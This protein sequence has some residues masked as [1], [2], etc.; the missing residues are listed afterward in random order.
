MSEEFGA[1]LKQLRREAGFGLRQFAEMI[2]DAASNYADIESGVRQPWPRTPD[3]LRHVAESLGL[4][5]GSHKCDKLFMLASNN[6]ALPPDLASVVDMPGVPVFLRTVGELRPSEEELR[7]LADS[8][9]RS[10]RRKKK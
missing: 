8:L 1:Y 2:G 7:K 3:K 6:V 10:R 9:R 4:E 5:E